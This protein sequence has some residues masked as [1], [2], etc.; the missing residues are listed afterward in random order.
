MKTA[1]IYLITNLINGK[2]YVGQTTKGYLKRW[3]DHC[4]YANRINIDRQSHQLIDKVID[5]YCTYDEF[6]ELYENEI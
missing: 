3:R 5:K 1:D 6:L 4:T 2:Q